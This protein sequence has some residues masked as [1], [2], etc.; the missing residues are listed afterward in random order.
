MLGIIRRQLGEHPSTCSPDHRNFE[1]YGKSS[2]CWLGLEEM[3]GT[4]PHTKLCLTRGLVIKHA[5]SEENPVHL[6]R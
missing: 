3:I 6:T 2:A 1:I 4:Q 5:T